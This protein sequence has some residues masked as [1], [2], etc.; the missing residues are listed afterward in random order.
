MN[1][2]DFDNK[3]KEYDLSAE[4][5]RGQ[6]FG[7]LSLLSERKIPS[8][9]EMD[10]LI[11][12]ISDLQRIYNE[13]TALAKA[14]LSKTELPPEESGLNAYI[15]A[16][17]TV[18]V[19]DNNHIITETG[20]KGAEPR[21][22]PD[23]EQI[24]DPVKQYKMLSPDDPEIKMQAEKIEGLLHRFGVPGSVTEIQCG[25]AFTQFGVEPGFIEQNGRKV[26]VRVKQIEALQRELENELVRKQ[27]S[28]EAPIPG[29]TYIGIHVPNK[30]RIPV[31]LREVIESGD[32]RNQTYGLGIALG[33]DI[34]GEVFSADLACMPHLLIAGATGS[35]KSV[36]IHAILSCLLLQNSPERLRLILID[37]KRAELT[38]YNGIPHLI[39]PVVTKIEQAINVLHWVLREVDLRQEHFTENDVCNIQE[40]NS[41]YP[42]KQ[43]PYIVVVIDELAHLM[44]E[45]APDFENIIV[46][47]AQ[48]ADTAGIHLIAATQRPSRDVITDPVKDCLQARIAFTV[49]TNRDSRVILDR[50]DAANLFGKGDIYYLS[51]EAGTPKRLQCV[52]VSD[53]EIRRIIT[54]WEEK[55]RTNHLSENQDPD[56]VNDMIPETGNDVRYPEASED[57]L[58]GVPPFRKWEPPVKKDGDPL[59]DEAVRIV[60]IAGRASANMLVSRLSIGYNRAHR[61]LTRMED[62]GIIGP[63]R[64]GAKPREILDHGE[65]GQEKDEDLLYDAAVKIVQRTGKSSAGILVEQLDI[66]YPHAGKLLARMEDEGILGPMK[67]GGKPREIPDHG[68]LGQKKDEQ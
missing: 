52:Q 54:Y 61:L 53:D 44:M 26:R 59:Y 28:I 8:G 48:G 51:P 18:S 33:K 45:A 6:L 19:S 15:A 50:A 67:P 46:R 4:N 23:P 64:P 11:T 12:N 49:A 17:E 14:N 10:A 41:K 3:I 65:Y 56:L 37:P 68:E 25:Q 21:I 36:C 2:A 7:L 42:D 58:P 39:T 20:E 60:R 38:G 22:L 24:L 63:M 47:L 30:I 27:L 40:Y 9:M 66:D 62:E 16:V 55:S 1:Y 5:I 13:I 29:K 31:S 35:G 34:N 43:L 32:F 57:I